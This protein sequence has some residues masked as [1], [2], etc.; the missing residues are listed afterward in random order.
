MTESKLIFMRQYLKTDPK[1][2]DLAFLAE[3]IKLFSE[4]QGTYPNYGMLPLGSAIESLALGVTIPVIQFT[5]SK[6]CQPNNLF[7][8]YEEKK[9]ADNNQVSD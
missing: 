8:W 9:D 1:Q 5:Q 3:C 7:L 2:S 4:K 6:L